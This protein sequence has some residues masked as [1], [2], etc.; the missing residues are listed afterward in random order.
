MYVCWEISA[1]EWCHEDK[2]KIHGGGRVH[3]RQFF[4]PR[5]TRGEST[6]NNGCCTTGAEQ[7]CERDDCKCGDHSFHVIT[8]PLKVRPER[9]GGRYLPTACWT[10]L[11][12][13]VPMLLE[14]LLHCFRIAILPFVREV[15]RSQ[16]VAV[17][18]AGYILSQWRHRVLSAAG[19]T[20]SVPPFMY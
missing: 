7:S 18:G 2:P 3:R 19:Q 17:H 13:L 10:V 5:T 9:S 15:I 4:Q 6:S 12:L 1:L 16:H 14:P 20:G 11:P 8:L